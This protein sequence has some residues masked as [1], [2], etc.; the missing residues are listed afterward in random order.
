VSRCSRGGEKDFVIERKKKYAH[1]SWTETE[2]KYVGSQ[3]KLLQKKHTMY[4]S[5]KEGILNREQ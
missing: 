4:L 5:G 2:K 1:T 3:T